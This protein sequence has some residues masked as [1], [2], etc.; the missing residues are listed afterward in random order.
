MFGN[1]C[2]S[3]TSSRLG[4][5]PFA[6]AFSI[7]A[8]RTFLVRESSSRLTIESMKFSLRCVILVCMS[9]DPSSM[10]ERRKDSGQADP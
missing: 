2:C 7:L 5:S 3:S 6:K 1:V 4:I 10:L 8:E 9:L